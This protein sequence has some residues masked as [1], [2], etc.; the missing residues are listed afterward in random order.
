MKDKQAAE[1]EARLRKALKR[2]QRPPF[3][4]RGKPSML[5]SHLSHSQIAQQDN[6]RLFDGELEQYIE[7]LDLL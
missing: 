6:K 4:R 5:R 1:H 2:S 3:H 7:R